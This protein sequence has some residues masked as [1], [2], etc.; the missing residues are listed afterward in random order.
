MLRAG[1]L[2]LPPLP[3]EAPPVPALRARWPWVLGLAGAAAAA[4]LAAVLWW[5]RPDN[6]L[7]PVFVRAETQLRDGNATAALDTVEPLL[8]C[9]LTP[10]QQA[11]AKDLLE[12]AGHA[13]ARADLLAGNFPRVLQTAERL[14]GH[15]ITSARVANLR[16]QALQRQPGEVTLA[17]AGKGS[18]LGYGYLPNGS[19]ARSPTGAPR[20]AVTER[21]PQQWEEAIAVNPADVALRLNYAQFLLDQRKGEAKGQFEAALKLD[22]ESVA[23]RLGLGMFLY[24]QAEDYGAALEQFQRVLRKEPENV[25][26][27]VD[28]AM[29]LEAL[30]RDVDA[31]R[32]WQR[33]RDLSGDGKLRGLIDAHLAAPK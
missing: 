23:A 31:Q 19:S 22:P 16:L 11:R 12:R 5:P 26:A 15:G 30:H 6:G 24:D 3:D 20:D 8:A 9:D 21:L 29:A 10:A 18:L 4:V 28:A 2:E 33:A 27:H 14:A 1:A 17:L 7:D 25:A 32:H 13:R